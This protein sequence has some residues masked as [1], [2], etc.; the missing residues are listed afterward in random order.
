MRE[1]RE[2]VVRMK[3]SAEAGE[4]L[5]FAADCHRLLHM[6]DSLPSET[7]MLSERE[8]LHEI[9]HLAWHVCESSEENATTGAITVDSQDF[10]ALSEALPMEHPPH[11]FLPIGAKR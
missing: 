1:I 3:R 11:G 8:R 9:V 2:Y 6:L 4:L 7:G 5:G 10:K